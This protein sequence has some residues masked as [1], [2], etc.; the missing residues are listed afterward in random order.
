[1]A[2]THRVLKVMTE[3]DG[4]SW[5]KCYADPHCRKRGPKKHSVQLAIIA[6]GVSL[7]DQHPRKKRK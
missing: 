5:V 3:A 4:C 7:S 2:C 6:F 1:M